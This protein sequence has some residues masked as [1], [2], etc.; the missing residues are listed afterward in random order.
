MGR[1]L[2]HIPSINTQNK[3]NI[4]KQFIFGEKSRAHD[5]F[6]NE[7][8]L[9]YTQEAETSLKTTKN[10]NN[11]Q[12]THQTSSNNKRSTHLYKSKDGYYHP[13]IMLKSYKKQAIIKLSR[14]NKIK[15][16]NMKKLIDFDKLLVDKEHD[17]HNKL[18]KI[19]KKR[20]KKKQSKKRL[21]RKEKLKKLLRKLIIPSS[22]H[23]QKLY[24]TIKRKRMQKQYNKENL[25]KFKFHEE[26]P[27]KLRNEIINIINDLYKRKGLYVASEMK[28]ILLK[29]QDY[30]GKEKFDIGRIEG[31]TYKIHMKPGVEPIKEKVSN[32]PPNQEEEMKE[33]LIYH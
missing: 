7:L 28:D 24:Q 17:S 6:K 11:E 32:L 3:R 25:K 23:K 22:T 2:G 8:D 4:V 19:I 30:I 31:I 15:K 18:D 1:P 12:S 21:S 13:C 9:Q 20:F 33:Q 14:D 27:E 29:Y 10:K 16:V 5:K 26:T